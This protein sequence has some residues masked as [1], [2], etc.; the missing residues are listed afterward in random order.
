M[1]IENQ[2]SSHS[3]S[4]LTSI[5]TGL[6][7]HTPHKSLLLLFTPAF[8][9]Y[10]DPGNPFLS[11]VINK[12]LGPLGAKCD[13]HEFTLNATV[14]VVDGVTS[15]LFSRIKHGTRSVVDGRELALHEPQAPHGSEGLA[16]L[17]AD[18]ALLNLQPIVRTTAGHSFPPCI[19]FNL[20]D[21]SSHHVLKS[22]KLPTSNT[23]FQN[24]SETTFFQSKWLNRSGLLTPIDWHDLSGVSVDCPFQLTDQATTLL[25]ARLIPLTVPRKIEKSF[26]NV[27][28]LLSDHTAEIHEFPA[29]RDLERNIPAYISA[30]QLSPEAIGQLQ[31]YAVVTS[32]EIQDEECRHGNGIFL[33]GPKA[34][35]LPLED[36]LP[37]AWSLSNT[38]F[39]YETLLSQGATFH[40][41]LGGG[42]GWGSSAGL[43]TVAPMDMFEPIFADS[44]S[45]L[46]VYGNEDAHIPFLGR[47]VV[48]PGKYVQFFVVP[49]PGQDLH[50]HYIDERPPLPSE[51]TF[52]ACCIPEQS[53]DTVLDGISGPTFSA[54]HFGV[55]STRAIGYELDCPQE[56]G[57]AVS[58]TIAVDVPFSMVTIRNPTLKWDS[59]AQ[60]VH[61]ASAADTMAPSGDSPLF[62]TW[63]SNE[64]TILEPGSET[65]K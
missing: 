24:G 9:R 33:E 41:V 56:S 46:D 17:A 47:S 3:I 48:S 12:L 38:K 6:D 36:L 55:V 34:S 5:E 32:L 45:A 57:P 22:V 43:I 53:P 23:I 7:P 54:G 50:A 31:V 15:Q 14:A 10:L 39:R 4:R 11:D 13:P 64:S 40:R 1:L 2:S 44:P 59:S 60:S 8:A 20:L 25:Q 65:S 16:Y 51:I 27:I 63:D 29:S 26:G 19:S 61:G 37:K 35:H 62:A 18:A 49:N 58:R 21:N 30:K 28:R 42:G 52:E